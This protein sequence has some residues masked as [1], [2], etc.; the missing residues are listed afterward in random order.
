MITRTIAR[1]LL[2]FFVTA[3]G[4]ELLLRILI[5]SPAATISDSELGWKYRPHATILHS[6]EGFARV[7][8]NSL[9]YNDKEPESGSQHE[10]IIALGDSFTE[11]LQV[12]QHQN[13]T[14][15]AEDTTP[16]MDVF[17]AGRSD[18]TAIHYPIMLNQF[19]QQISFDKAVV[20]FTSRDVRDLFDAEFDLEYDQMGTEIVEISFH[21]R[22][23]SKL[24]VLLD[25]I[26]S[27][28]SLATYLKD[29]LT[30]LGVNAPDAPE[31][32]AVRDEA[33]SREKRERASQIFRYILRRLSARLPTYALYIPSLDYHPDGVSTE[34]NISIEAREIIRDSAN[35]AG[36]PFAAVDELQRMYEST[37]TPPTGFQNSDILYGHLNVRGHVA[38]SEALVKLVRPSCSA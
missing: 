17:N 38:V 37:R 31:S 16:C 30:L 12:P 4:A 24:R 26:F 7:R 35:E 1:I 34:D 9:G 10:R 36:V 29:R 27:N 32:A 25:P 3:A 2:A 20:V 23:L 18:A 14:S 13:F 11:A 6:S 19:R 15:V 22:Q 5:I 28:S 8:L 33:L 21:G